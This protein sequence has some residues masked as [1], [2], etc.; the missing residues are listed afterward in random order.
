MSYMHNKGTRKAEAI[1]K[2]L[3]EYS[4][5]DEDEYLAGLVRRLTERQVENL[6]E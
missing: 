5:R 1:I 2:E 4:K 6:D 3:A